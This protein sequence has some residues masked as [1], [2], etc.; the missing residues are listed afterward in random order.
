MQ[1]KNL[2]KHTKTRVSDFATLHNIMKLYACQL[3]WT[4]KHESMTDWVIMCVCYESIQ[5]I[6]SL[7]LYLSRFTK[8][9]E[10]PR[11]QFHL[12]KMIYEQ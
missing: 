2:I 11:T 3:R 12:I 10:E 6:V 8:K 7:G 4:F 1:H 5:Q 9:R